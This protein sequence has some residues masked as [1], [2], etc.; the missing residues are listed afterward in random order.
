MNKSRTETGSVEPR[1][2]WPIYCSFFHSNF[3]KDKVFNSGSTHSLCHDRYPM[4]KI[5]DDSNFDIVIIS[6]KVSIFYMCTGV[7]KLILKLFCVFLSLIKVLSL[8][9]CSF[10]CYYLLLFSIALF[11]FCYDLYLY[12]PHFFLFCVLSFF[13]S[14]SIFFLA[15]FFTIH[16]VLF[17]YTFIIPLLYSFF[18]LCFCLHKIQSDD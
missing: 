4:T 14:F 3:F 8:S 16:S 2:L 13:P 10:V 6:S 11:W 7:C 1:S 17:L 15:L 5:F 9:L 12:Y 18:L